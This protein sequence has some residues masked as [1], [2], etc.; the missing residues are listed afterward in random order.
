TP[1]DG[2]ISRSA[3]MWETRDSHRSGRR[4]ALRP[5]AEQGEQAAMGI[6]EVGDHHAVLQLV[7]RDNYLAAEL[8]GLRGGRGDVG[9]L[10]HE[11]RV[12]RDV[13]AGVEDATGG[14]G[15]TGGGDERVRAVGGE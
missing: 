9:H 15:V 6:G 13:A 1:E 4:S 2:D 14:A 3:A 7:R 10:D 12:R 11:D 8:F 5:R